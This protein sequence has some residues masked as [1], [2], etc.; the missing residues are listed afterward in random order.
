VNRVFDIASAIILGTAAVAILTHP[1]TAGNVR[2]L[3]D[4]WNGS[5]RTLRGS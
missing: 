1:Q 3:G 4:L 5:L 2:A